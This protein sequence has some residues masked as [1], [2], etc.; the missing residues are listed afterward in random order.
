MFGNLTFMRKLNLSLL[1][2]LK[3]QSLGIKVLDL[4]RREIPSPDLQHHNLELPS[5]L[6]LR[7][8]HAAPPS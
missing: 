6:A 8:R 1:A 7:T 3:H 4:V 5:L 2:A